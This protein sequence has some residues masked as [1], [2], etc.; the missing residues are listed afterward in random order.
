MHGK[1]Y[2]FEDYLLDVSEQR[3]QKNGADIPLPPKVFE[4]LI[5]LIKRHGQLVT[6]RELMDEVWQNTFV[7]ETNLRYSIH[8]LRRALPE[9]FIETVPKRGYRFKPEVKSF[10]SEE[11]IKLHTGNFKK[12][13]LLKAVEK[14]SVKTRFAFGK[15]AL[16]A[17][18]ALF[19]AAFGAVYYFFLRESKPTVEDKNFKTIA[20]LPFSIIGEK[21]DK[22]PEIQK[23]LTD[24]LSFNLGKICGLKVT[25]TKEIQNYFGKDFDALEVGKNLKTDEVLTGTYRLENNLA[26]VNVALLRVADGET[27]W[28]KTFTVK[29]NTQIETENS[30]ALPIARQIELKNAALIDEQLLKHSNISEESKKNYLIARQI[31]R[32]FEFNRRKEMIGLF[33]KITA[34]EPNWAL[35]FSG[36]AQA[37]VMTHGGRVDWARAETVARR[38]LELD[39]SNADA[40]I[41]LGL[42]Y[43]HHWNWE[44]AEQAYQTAIKLDPESAV[45]YNEYGVMLDFQRR[46]AEAETMLKKA[47]EIEPFSPLFYNSLCEHYYYDERYDEALS[48]CDRAEQIDPDFWLTKKKLVWIYIQKGMFDALE[49]IEYGDLSESEKNKNARIK[50]LVDRNLQL[51]WKRS[52][53]ERLNDPNRAYSPVQI[54]AYYSLLGEN[55]K[56]LEH[57]EK[58]VENVNWEIHRAN[59]SPVFKPL[60]KESRFVELMKKINLNP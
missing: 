59:P 10:T 5:A 52:L 34:A 7:E 1:I 43:Q 53:D 15:Y 6:Y 17:A 58:G 20:V 8:A 22:A 21:P 56:A 11:F 55:D 19:L 54:A 40:F 42:F 39:G 26:R 32:K 35:G 9:H 4:V 60:R 38:G 48:Q 31:F 24:A 45:A 2:Q 29:E 13:E 33:E 41:V 57:L 12:D 46:F 16:V 51:Y 27:V 49:K 18:L 44:K 37:L 3:L 36:F 47:V 30:I 25:P 23:G 50:P 14:H 28:T